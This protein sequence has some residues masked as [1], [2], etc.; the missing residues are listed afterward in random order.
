M[1]TIYCIEDINDL[2]YVGSTKTSLARRLA[3]H[4]NNKGCSSSKLNLYNCIIYP[5]ETCSESDR[6]EREEYWMDKIDCVNKNKCNFDKKE[7]CRNWRKN[8]TEKNKEIKKNY[9]IKS[10]V[11]SVMNDLITQIENASE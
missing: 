8:N 2:K 7:Y 4:K 1:A 6:Y 9:Y 10:V 11:K 5:L 3:S